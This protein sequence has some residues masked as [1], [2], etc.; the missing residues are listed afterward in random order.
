MISLAAREKNIKNLKLPG[1]NCFEHG[2]RGGL[3][4]HN[5]G[6]QHGLSEALCSSAEVTYGAV[7]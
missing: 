4:Y 1:T 2:A 7:N 5:M 3:G 6:G